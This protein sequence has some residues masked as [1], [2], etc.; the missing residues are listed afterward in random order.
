MLLVCVAR[1]Q[2][3]L[4]GLVTAVQGLH[5]NTEA[6]APD[7]EQLR[8]VRT[9]I[10]AMVLRMEDDTPE[11]D[12]RRRAWA[13]KRE[14]VATIASFVVLCATQVVGIVALNVMEQAHA[15]LEASIGRLVASK[16]VPVLRSNAAF[17]A[18][19]REYPTQRKPNANP[20]VI[21][22]HERDAM[23]DLLRRDSFD[24]LPSL[25]LPHTLGDANMTAIIRRLV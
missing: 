17:E 11:P 15:D 10:G 14:A 16:E 25:N 5:T 7:A 24:G 8:S 13:Q 21:F 18:F 9:T 3:Q 6:W 20:S 1:Q 2:E 12:R 22:D 23:L 19:E 4:G